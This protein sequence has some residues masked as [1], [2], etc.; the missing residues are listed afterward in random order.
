MISEI[1]VRSK[2]TGDSNMFEPGKRVDQN[3]SV[4][5]KVYTFVGRHDINM[6]SLFKGGL[7]FWRGAKIKIL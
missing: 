7:E 2:N 4:L 5:Q 1:A 3:C 6:R